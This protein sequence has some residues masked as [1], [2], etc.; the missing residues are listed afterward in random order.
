MA[1]NIPDF[2]SEKEEADWWYDH[3]EDLSD[4]MSES[5]ANGTTRNVRQM[6]LE[7][8]GLLLPDAYVSVP[9]TNEDLASAKALADAVGISST[10]YISQVIHDAL[11][12]K[13]AA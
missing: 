7:D 11:K 1:L 6:L 3:R 13:Q 5:V 4:Y 12:A 2:A 10:Q 9:F 8:H